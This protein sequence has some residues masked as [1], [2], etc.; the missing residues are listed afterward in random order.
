MLIV[1]RALAIC[2]LLQ[3][4]G[5]PALAQDPASL[6]EAPFG[7]TWL[8]SR[9]AVADAGVK[10]KAPMRSEFGDTFVV[11]ELPKELPD[12]AYAILCF[13]DEDQLI[14]IVAVGGHFEND[15]DGRRLNARYEELKQLLGKKYGVGQSERH[16]DKEYEATRFALGLQLRKN[17]TYS[18]F[19]PPDMKVELSAVSLEPQKTGW[20]IIFEYVPGMKRFELLR[21][22]TEEKAL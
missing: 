9:L 12:L 22:Q 1:V 10:L 11:G 17:W 19:S 13:G 5:I 20:R 16:I 6:P 2:C 21:K 18:V 3:L 8:A 14:R 7:L 4:P 15:F